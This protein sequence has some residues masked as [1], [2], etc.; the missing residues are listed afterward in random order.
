MYSTYTRTVTGTQLAI[1]CAAAPDKMDGARV[2][3]Y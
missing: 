3:Q 1:T 2:R